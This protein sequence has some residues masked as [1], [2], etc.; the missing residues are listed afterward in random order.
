MTNAEH[1]TSKMQQIAEAREK[2]QALQVHIF[3]LEGAMALL[4]ELGTP[5]PPGVE[6]AEGHP[7]AP[8]E[9]EK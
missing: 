7:A 6:V 1:M 4:M 5:L 2:I 8:K 3:R 9:P